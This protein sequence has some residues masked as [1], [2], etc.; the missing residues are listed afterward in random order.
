MTMNG[1]STARVFRRC[2]SDIKVGRFEKKKSKYLE[3][4]KPRSRGMSLKSRE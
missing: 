4:R 3:D 2:R 1:G